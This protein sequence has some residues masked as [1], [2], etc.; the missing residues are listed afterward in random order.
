M[1]PDQQ[2]LAEILRET[3][4]Y[5]T[6]AE[7]DF[8]WTGWNSAEDALRDLDPLIAALNGGETP[9]RARMQF[10]FAPTG[11]LQEL[12]ISSGWDVEFLDLARSSTPQKRS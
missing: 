3:R 11:P 2:A 1:T 7:N 5:I 8:A 10:L 4:A 12:S 6:R 9:D